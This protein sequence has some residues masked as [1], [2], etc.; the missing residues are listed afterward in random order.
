MEVSAILTPDPVSL[1]PQGTLDE[2]MNLMD[3][4]DIRHL[5]VVE[6][7]HVV[8][9][10]SNRDLLEATGWKRN[11]VWAGAAR[12]PKHVAEIMHTSPV[13]LAPHDS[14]VSAA[15]EMSLR[16]IGCLPV[17]DDGRLVGIVTETDLMRAYVSCCEKAGDS[18][19]IDPLVE[20]LMTS[21][22]M[23]VQVDTTL[24]EATALCRTTSIRHLPVAQGERLVGILSDRALRRAHGERLP[25]E[26]PVEDLMAS[27]P[28]TVGPRQHLSVAARR[29]L[30]YKISSL[31][32]VLGDRLI[33][34]LTLTDVLDHCMGSLRE[35][36]LPSKGRRATV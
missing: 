19:D 10:V 20:E 34:I 29:L 31:P 17:V 14:V 23:T 35:P 22:A 3:Q 12:A 36:D 21:N 8:G 6:G 18:A 1:P 32:V 33:G 24:G 2:A 16:R 26:T 13:T 11:G 4:H 28:V 27:D 15:L 5:P 30:E 7:G 9:V 25:D